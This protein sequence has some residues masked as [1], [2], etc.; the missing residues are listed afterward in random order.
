VQGLDPEAA[1]RLHATRVMQEVEAR[2]GATGVAP[3][4]EVR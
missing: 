1:L 2:T 3:A 4:A